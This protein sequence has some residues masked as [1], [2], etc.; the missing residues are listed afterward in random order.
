M[1]YESNESG[2][3]EVYVVEYPVAKS[4]TPVSTS[5]GFR[6]QWTQNGREIMFRAVQAVVEG[7]RMDGSA[8]MAVDVSVSNTGTFQAGVPR[9]LATVQGLRDWDVTADGQRIIAIVD[10]DNTGALLD[11][12]PIRIIQNWQPK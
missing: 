1:A 11:L 10:E 2:R 4:R 3:N 6:P 12:Q 5:G 9:K 8:I 7:R